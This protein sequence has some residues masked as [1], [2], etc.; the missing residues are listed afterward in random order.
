MVNCF[1][2]IFT[3]R[4]CSPADS[5]GLTHGLTHDLLAF[6]SMLWSKIGGKLGA[7]P[8]AL[9]AVGAAGAAG[10]AYSY[11]YRFASCIA[12]TPFVPVH[13][14]VLTGGEELASYDE[15]TVSHRV[16]CVYIVYCV[17]SVYT[18]YIHCVTVYMYCV[19][20][21][22]VSSSLFSS[23]ARAVANPRRSLTSPRRWRRGAMTC[24]RHRRCPR[25]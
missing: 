9:A 7:L 6:A 2:T 23:Q 13:R 19:L 1:E 16:Y 5:C 24:T 21:N 4:S 15:P 14:I 12:G 8:S 11:D 17:H 25:F 18:L 22:E 20:L 3:C 10:A